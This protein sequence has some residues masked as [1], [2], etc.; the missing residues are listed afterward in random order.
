VGV[1]LGLQTLAANPLPTIDHHQSYF[2][3]PPTSAGVGKWEIVVVTDQGGPPF[4]SH[5]LLRLLRLC[6]L[7][8]R[9]LL[10][11]HQY[12]LTESRSLC[13]SNAFKLLEVPHSTLTTAYNKPRYEVSIVIASVYKRLLRSP[14]PLHYWHR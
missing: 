12:F 8:I 4:H 9:F 10:S 3:P 7:R 11:R 2:I 13:L 5:L 1:T 6:V 14:V